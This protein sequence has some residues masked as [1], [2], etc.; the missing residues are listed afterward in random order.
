[1]QQIKLVL[2]LCF[3]GIS[4]YSQGSFSTSLRDNL[5]NITGDKT[6]ALGNSTATE[7]DNGIFI[8]YKAGQASIAG[9]NTFI[10]FQSGAQASGNSPY[11]MFLGA[12]SGYQIIDSRA[13][14]GIGSG[15]GRNMN[16]ALSNVMIGS[17]SGGYNQG[18]NNI[19]LGS[20]SGYNNKGHNNIFIGVS[21]G[22]SNDTGIENVYLG[23]GSGQTNTGSRNVFIGYRSGYNLVDDLSE[24]LFIENSESQ[25]PLIY[26]DFAGDK[27]GI[28]TTNLINSIGGQNI[29]NYS[30]YAE[31]GI[32]TDEVRVRTTW[33]D[34]VFEDTYPLQSIEDLE[35][36]ISTN[37]HLPN[38]PTSK[39]VESQGLEIGDI[40]RI[41]QEK[42]EE[43]TLYVI[44]LHEMIT[45]LKEEIK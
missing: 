43:L 24:K 28:N 33:A 26:G 27:V 11:N 10:G 34:Y 7:P 4:S 2:Y 18:D 13:N 35:L 41:Q 5:N 42:I 44:K 23:N 15:S 21:S 1:M 40:T 25:T 30:L 3:I 6:V 39:E 38:C 19:F 16:G 12:N 8:G 36:F 37:G 32:L 31:G 14:V 29:S 45:E 22:I 9:D 20:A 17:S